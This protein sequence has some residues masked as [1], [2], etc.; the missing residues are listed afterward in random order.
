MVAAINGCDYCI[1]VTEPT[2]FGLHDLALAVDVLAEMGVR[3]G[4]V[5]NKHTGENTLIE[6]YCSGHGIENT[7]KN[8]LR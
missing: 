1:L 2:P 3:Y 8:T 5:L 7:G 6:D 4:V